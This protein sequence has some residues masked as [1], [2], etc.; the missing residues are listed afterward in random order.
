MP[1]VD[2]YAPSPTSDLHLGNLRTALAGWL[3]TRREEGRWL[4]RV[5]DLDAAVAALEE[6]PQ[7]NQLQIARLKKQK[8][9]LKD[10]IS[11][12]EAQLKP[13]IIA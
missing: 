9:V 3:L 10:Q 4:L 12:L 6:Q 7:P 2:R 8:L 1:I 13:D 11:K 5:E